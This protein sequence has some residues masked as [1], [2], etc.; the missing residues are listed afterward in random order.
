MFLKGVKLFCKFLYIIL[1]IVSGKLSV[2]LYS[3]FLNETNQLV[4]EL[5][6]TVVSL[7][8]QFFIFFGILYWFNPKQIKTEKVVENLIEV[9]LQITVVLGVFI[10]FVNRSL[11]NGTYIFD[12]MQL[13][14]CLISYKYALKAYLSTRS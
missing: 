4:L 10:T 7:I 11:V 13:L 2:L 6:Y 8:V 3:P 14:T 1:P 5:K 12:V 9:L